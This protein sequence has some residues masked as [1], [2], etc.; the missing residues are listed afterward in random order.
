MSEKQLIEGCLQG[1]RKAQE[2][3]YNTYSRRMMGLCMRYVSDRET[4]RDLLQDGFIKLFTS[5]NLYA[6]KGPF[7]AWMRMIFVNVAIEH[8]RKK[9][10][11]RD[12][13]DL[14]NIPEISMDETV[15][16]S[17]TEEAIMDL[18]RQLPNGYRTIFNLFAVE[19]YS[20]REI[21][22]KLNISEA[23]SRSQYNRARQW[24][25]DRLEKENL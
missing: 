15:V 23:T 9:D 16:S 2:E 5:L 25:R 13:S 19:G 1:D 10:I 14:E 21:G 22:E 11:L 17:L 4:A 3:L 12:T 20:H 18:V 24:L 7:E 6:G 8:L